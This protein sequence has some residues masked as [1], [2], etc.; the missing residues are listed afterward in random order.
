[1]STEGRRTASIPQTA[2]ARTSAA[3]IPLTASAR[4][5]PL[6]PPDVD[7]LHDEVEPEESPTRSAVDEGLPGVPCPKCQRGT[8]HVSALDVDFWP[9]TAT[10]GAAEV[11]C[12]HC[13]LRFVHDLQ[14]EGGDTWSS[15][16]TGGLLAIGPA[17][18]LAADRRPL[19]SAGKRNA[20]IIRQA[21]ALEARGVDREA[22]RRAAA[23]VCGVVS[24]AA[25]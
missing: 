4:P 8:F 6:Q 18:V 25:G 1:M 5:V 20:A 10:L 13:T 3:R 19:V 22:A 12:G 23:A 15:V 16:Q 14:G 24:P 2:S 21:M 9:A 11:R 17:D 7:E